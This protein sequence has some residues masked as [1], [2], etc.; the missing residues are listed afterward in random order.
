M[1]IQI[2]VLPLLSRELHSM[3]MSNST[4]LVHLESLPPCLHAMQSQLRITEL[5][6]YVKTRH[7]TNVSDAHSWQ[8][9]KAYNTNVFVTVK[10]SAFVR[11]SI[12]VSLKIFHVKNKSL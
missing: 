1:N 4:S 12:R 10:I 8:I 7:R 9:I 5:T 11:I 6:T 3:E 2:T